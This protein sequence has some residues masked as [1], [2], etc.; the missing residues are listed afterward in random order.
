MEDAITGR[1]LSPDPH[2]QD[3]G[4]TQSFNRYSYVNNNPLSYADPTGFEASNFFRDGLSEFAAF[5]EE[6]ASFAGLGSWDS[7]GR[8]GVGSGGSGN[9]AGTGTQPAPEST[10][11]TSDPKDASSSL[12]PGLAQSQGGDPNAGWS[13]SGGTCPD[14]VSQ[15]ANK[16]MSE[17]DAAS[18]SLAFAGAGAAGVEAK[19]G[20]HF[21][22]SPNGG[23][24][25]RAW[26]NGAGRAYKIS[27]LTKSFGLYGLAAGTAFDA[28]SLQDGDLTGVQF[29]TNLTLG[30]LGYFVPLYGVGSLNVLYISNLYPGGW[31][32]YYEDFFLN[33]NNPLIITGGYDG[34]N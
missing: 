29:G 20:E 2:V 16:S 10:V 13:C 23:L 8:H 32:G 1:F 3:L 25:T 21:L 5:G 33:P 11:S 18:A 19:F 4:N 7:N 9:P 24:Y 26:A 14:L 31:Q 30:V 28:Q 27:N 15:A 12:D 6:F 22:G 17:S 34:L